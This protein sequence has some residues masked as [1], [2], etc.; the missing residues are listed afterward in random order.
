[1]PATTWLMLPGLRSS[2]RNEYDIVDIING[3]P[4]TKRVRLE[5]C[6]IVWDDVTFASDIKRVSE[7]ISCANM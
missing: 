3:S 6:D 1:M 4:H 2:D 7:M 5:D